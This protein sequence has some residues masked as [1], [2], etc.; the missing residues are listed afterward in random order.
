MLRL[1]AASLLVTSLA[2]VV[3]AQQ[4]LRS[5]PQAGAV[6]PGP[7]DVFNINGKIAPG[8]NHCLVCEFAL[9][10]VV[11][12][13]TREPIVRKTGGAAKEIALQELIQK[14]DAVAD[15]YDAG[16]W[17]KGTVIFLSPYA[18]S[19]VSE[20]PITD[21]DKLLEEARDRDAL[22]A[23][24]KPRGDGIKHVILAAHPEAG[25]KGYQLNPKA[26]VTVVFY[27][28][29]KVIANWAFEDGKLSS[30]D[31]DA[32]M[33]KVQSTLGPKRPSDDE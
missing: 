25:P 13:F 21:V 17:L 7:F 18:R 33:K 22:V 26:E 16:E 4:P 14:L 27:Q 6:L 19:S 29:L 3:A 8:R 10:P 30:A 11:M 9:E 15:K 24:L 20:G 1:I 32:I 28:R 31:V 2:A 12:V 5:G 23:R